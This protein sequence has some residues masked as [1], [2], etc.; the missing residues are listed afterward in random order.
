MDNFP[1]MGETH[2][3]NAGTDL[4]VVHYEYCLGAEA[5]HNYVCFYGMRT[6]D[7]SKTLY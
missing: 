2:A 5:M 1:F 7:R 6:E 3:K 4:A